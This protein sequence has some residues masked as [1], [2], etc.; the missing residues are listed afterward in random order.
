MLSSMAPIKKK[1]KMYCNP[2]LIE[3]GATWCATM[4]DVIV[5]G[6]T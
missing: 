3:R 2:A 6:T 5:G 4:K 1:R